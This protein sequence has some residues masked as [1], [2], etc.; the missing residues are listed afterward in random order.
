MFLSTWI[1]NIQIDSVLCR[2]NCSVDLCNTDTFY[3][4]VQLYVTF[5]ANMAQKYGVE[6]NNE[7]TITIISMICSLTRSYYKWIAT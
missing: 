4:L 2:D 3:T 5:D 7:F 1:S 6:K